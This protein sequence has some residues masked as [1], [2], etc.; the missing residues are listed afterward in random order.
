MSG[1][2]QDDGKRNPVRPRTL[3][4]GIDYVEN[5]L[6]TRYIFPIKPGA[7]FPPLIKNNLADA[8]NDPE[9]L[10]K[11]EEQWPGCNW[12][13]AHRKSKLLVADIDTNKA[14]GKVG[15]ATFD[16]LDLVYGWP[17]TETTTTPSGGFHLI[18][19]GWADDSHPAHIMALGENGIG[20]D[21]DSP[22]YTLI[23]GCTFD[24][25]TS[26]VGNG[27]EAVRCPEWIYD[28]IKSSKSKSRIA[29]AGEVVIEL[30]QERNIDTAIDYLINDAEP[31]IQGSGGDYNLLKAAY[32][33][34]DLGI[35][36][37]LGPQLLDEY[38]NPRCEPP[39][40]LDDLVKKMAGAYSYANLS[41]VGGKTAE[42]DFADDKP[43]PI[44]PMGDKKKIEATAKAR[45]KGR[46]NFGLDITEGKDI[47]PQVID[48]MWE[49]YLA[50]GNH[51]AF[52]GVQGDGKSQVIYSIAAAITN[53]DLWPGSQE[54]APQGRVILLNA[55]DRAQ[56]MLGPRL[57]AAG[58][59]MDFISIVNATRENGRSRKFSLLTDLERLANLA[60]KR[61][62]V[63]LITFDPVSSYLGGDLDSHSNTELRDALDP[64]TKMAW[65]TVTAVASVTH[66]NKSSTGVSALNRVMGGA[67]FTAAPRAAFA[68]IRDAK[69]PLTRML[70]PLKNNMSDEN[71]KYGMEFTLSSRE[72]AKDERNGRPVIAPYVVWGNKTSITADEAL[73]ANNA[74]L[75]PATKLEEA[76]GF[77]IQM[78][79]DGPRL[80]REVEAASAKRGIA[81][82]TL[83]RARKELDVISTKVEQRDGR[84]PWQWSLP[85]DAITPTA[86]G[87]IIKPAPL[88]EP[89]EEPDFDIGDALADF[90][91]PPVDD[92]FAELM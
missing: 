78:L 57:M 37:Q 84:G 7:K 67:G 43:E 25:G 83:R 69:Q 34:K 46:E 58:A 81:P 4:L 66:F 26:Y 88:S 11:W 51:T 44:T 75:R 92:P 9:Q 53:G 52:A 86:D 62:N 47:K 13:V 90:A 30:D 14:K 10:R 68:I 6:G 63:K 36:Q 73:A 1:K 19:E 20:K 54:R 79:A 16:G 5:H 48:W 31:S 38:F 28:T 29:D 8:S 33:L 61:G 89:D 55:E 17:E 42:A 80:V 21:I 70:L 65:D 85:D 87:K 72:V 49:G 3:A 91:E 56:D 27:A 71:V 60:N 2:A 45:E 74:K 64:I 40:D 35:S 76:N 39:W 59:N 24:D 23:P 82:D 32:Y 77:L 18:Y 22:N 41:K 15:Q 12:G 50:L